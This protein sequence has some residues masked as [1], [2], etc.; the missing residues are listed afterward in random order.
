MTDPRTSHRHDALIE[1]LDALTD[2]WLPAHTPPRTAGSG[3]RSVPRSRPPL[4]PE[5]L[6]IMDAAW[7]DLRSW[8]QLIMEERDLTVG[9]PG[10]TGPDLATF[11][12]RHADWMARHIA[13]EDCVDELRRHARLVGNL[14]TGR[15]VRRVMVGPCPEAEVGEDGLM[16][17]QC[18]GSLVALVHDED[19]FLPAVVRC[20]QWRDHVWTP[21]QWPA[22]GRRLG[23]VALPGVDEMAAAAASK[24]VH[25]VG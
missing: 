3:R 22:L 7:R 17:G 23:R 25:R 8:A 10:P 20:D 21:H 15:R 24:P 12:A 1:A 13:A 19:E 14:A 5:V 18:E 16:K 6:S 11:I 9:P 4:S 2:H